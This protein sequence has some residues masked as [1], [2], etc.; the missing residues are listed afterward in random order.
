[1]TITRA[2]IPSQID[3]FA[4]GGD[5]SNFDSFNESIAGRNIN[6]L[7]TKITPNQL[8]TPKI[9]ADDLSEMAFLSQNLA[10]LDYG[11]NLTKYK[12]RLQEFN[13]PRDRASIFDLASSLGAGLAATPN[14][15]GRSLGQGLSVGFGAFHQ[16]LK[17]DE[18]RVRE[19][20]RQIGLQ[21]AQ[22]AMQDENKAYEFM[23]KKSIERIKE[24]RKELK[25]TTIEFDKTDADGNLTRVKESI[26]NIPEN[27]ELLQEIANQQNNDYP[28]ALIL[29]SAGQQTNINMPRTIGPGEKL[30]EE[31]IQET[32][33]T[34]KAK[35][36]AAMPILDQV[37]TAFLL[38]Q[39]VGS[40]GF[41]PLSRATLGARE[42]II[43]MGLGGLL[44]DPESIPAQKALNQLSMSF[45]MAIVSQTKGAIS[46]K[47]MQLFIDA[48]PT[49][50]STYK[51][52]MKQL[53][54]LERLAARDRQFYRA[55]LD[56]YGDRIDEGLADRKLQLSLDK[57]SSKW[58]EENPLLTDADRK[59]LTDA[60][61]GKDQYGGKLSDDFVP[62]MFR[63]EVKK[64]ENQFYEYKS[65]LVRVMNQEQYDALDEGEKYIDADG[66]EGTKR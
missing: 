56:E 18:K 43:E 8:V 39:Q 22:L 49:L 63:L 2:Q 30:A 13:P 23:S 65:S 47:E 10:K 41:G 48:S 16:S 46:N 26:A 59:I 32:I 21:A 14:T 57:F 34:Y 29:S 40:D 60:I 24:S 51:G 4:T 6:V 37:G 17:E 3:P 20:E 54:L 15:G 38:A 53:E 25:F 12:E 28:N 5:V 55:Y 42:F 31:A 45:T 1:M 58:A 61:A 7:P 19:E 50:G 66:N 36:D 52:F 9:S 27:R 33:K 35:S 64:A 11:K 62:E 44:E